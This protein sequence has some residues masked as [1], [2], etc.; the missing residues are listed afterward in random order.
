VTA[1]TALLLLGA[2]FAA[3][4]AGT[5]AG[6]ASLFSYPA[7]L[8]AG[9]PPIAANVTNTV[10]LTATS[11]GAAAGSRPEL[12]GRGPTLRRLA[13][14]TALGGAV[15]A[16]LLLLTPSGAFEVVVPGLVAA[17]SVVLLAAPRLRRAAERRALGGRALTAG[18]FAVMIYAG[19]FGAAAGVL[20]LALLLV[21]LPVTVLQGNALKNVLLGLANAV[22]TVGFALAA[23]VHWVAA[24]PLAVGALAGA[25]LGPVVARRLPETALRIGI[26]VAG[27]GLAV[28][29]AV[30]AA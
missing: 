7:L 26:G 27:L 9:L 19:Y 5:V 22:A 8:V 28:V 18:L 10:A 23:P 11:I 30:R 15:G 29:L 21:G 13:P 2:G 16:G 25:R 14:M 17:A 20:I 24:L 1:P 4:L 6:L 12:A 3:G